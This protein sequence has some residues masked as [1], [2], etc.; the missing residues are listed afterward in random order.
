MDLDPVGGTPV[1]ELH[2]CVLE[3]GDEADRA[4]PEALR[5]RIARLRDR[6]EQLEKA[7][8]AGTVG[9]LCS[10]NAEGPS[11]EEVFLAMAPAAW[12]LDSP[13]LRRLGS[14]PFSWDLDLY[15]TDGD[16]MGARPDE[17]PSLG[18]LGTPIPASFTS[19]PVSRT[20]PPPTRHMV[21]ED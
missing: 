21:T 15:S 7:L 4:E 16:E 9:S 11:P 19:T 12:S 1:V 6:N 3:E 8:R 13:S 10:K 18:A 20:M 14:S 5:D 2:S 17:L